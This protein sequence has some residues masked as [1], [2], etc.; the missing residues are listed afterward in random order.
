MREDK[1][2]NPRVCLLFLQRQPMGTSRQVSGPHLGF[3]TCRSTTRSSSSSTATPA[4]SSDHREH[5]TAASVTTASVKR[6]LRWPAVTFVMFK[7]SFRPNVGADLGSYDSVKWEVSI[8]FV[9]SFL[10]KM[11]TKD[12]TSPKFLLTKGALREALFCM[13]SVG[14]SLFEVSVARF[15]RF[16]SK[17]CKPATVIGITMVGQCIWGGMRDDSGGSANR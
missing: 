16:I 3:A 13:E 7:P 1:L 17:A 4:R 14:L 15:M 11:K 5:L 12:K 9:H 8:V 10:S 6:N 2:A